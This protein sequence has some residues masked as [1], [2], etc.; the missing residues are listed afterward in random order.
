MPSLSQ[1]PAFRDHRASNESTQPEHP[2]FKQHPTQRDIYASAAYENT[3][4]KA[5]YRIVDMG[6]TAEQAREAL[7]MTDLGDGL[8]VDRAVELLL[9]RERAGGGKKAG[10][11]GGVKYM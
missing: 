2:A 4:E 1:H 7:K 5:I 11:Y 8:R 9:C 6:F 10:G 3:A